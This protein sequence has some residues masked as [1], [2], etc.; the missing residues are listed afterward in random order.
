[1]HEVPSDHASL[2]SHRSDVWLCGAQV[3]VSEG[4]QMRVTAFD[5]IRKAFVYALLLSPVAYAAIWR[6]L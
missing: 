1:M 4:F 3:R 2:D 6:L 5:C